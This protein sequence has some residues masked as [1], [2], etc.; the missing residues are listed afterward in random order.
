MTLK[1]HLTMVMQMKQICY[2]SGI[3][4]VTN[5]N[6]NLLFFLGRSLALLGKQCA[7]PDCNRFLASENDFCC[8]VHSQPPPSSP[9]KVIAK[10]SPRC[11]SADCLNIG[12]ACYSGMC[13]KCF[14]SWMGFGYS[15]RDEEELL[16]W[17]PS[18]Y[19]TCFFDLF[20]APNAGFRPGI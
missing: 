16:S 20:L 10:S 9:S 1:Y 4:S 17:P 15:K 5:I 7:K 12:V 13:S 3:K 14:A 11:T 2:Y 8:A 18:R 6:L 19:G